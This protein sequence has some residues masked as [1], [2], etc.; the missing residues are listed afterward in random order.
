MGKSSE[1]STTCETSETLD[2]FDYKERHPGI[3]HTISYSMYIRSGI[4]LKILD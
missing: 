2:M 3:N 1:K 4:N